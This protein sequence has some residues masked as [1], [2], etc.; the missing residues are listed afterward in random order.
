MSWGQHVTATDSH[1]AGGLGLTK[2]EGRL[3]GSLLI[4]NKISVGPHYFI[5][6]GYLASAYC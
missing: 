4:W 5:K 6:A 1:F 3:G 2:L